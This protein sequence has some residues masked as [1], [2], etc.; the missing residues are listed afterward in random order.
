MADP[1][2]WLQLMGLIWEHEVPASTKVT[3]VVTASVL[4]AITTITSVMR[5]DYRGR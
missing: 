1:R 5:K 2:A 4:L 3:C